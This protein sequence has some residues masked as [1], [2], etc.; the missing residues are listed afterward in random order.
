MPATFSTATDTGR[1]RA[2]NEDALFA[3]PPVF[4]VADGMGGPQ[5]GEIAS[6]ITAKA[7]E[8]YMPQGP[9]AERELPKL[10]EKINLNIYQLAL[11]ENRPGMG[12]TVTAAQVDGRSVVLAHVGDSRAY[13][14]RGG[15]LRQ[16]T[17]DHS[18]V[19]EMVRSGELTAEEASDH[20]QRSIITRA[21]GVD[22]AVEVDTSRLDWEPG[23]V[24]ML[25]S[26]GLYSMIPDGEIAG[27]L[28][29]WDD[30]NGMAGAL[31]AKANE[32]GG[33][34]NISVVLFCPDGSVRGEVAGEAD[35]GVLRLP[36]HA[37]FDFELPQSVLDGAR[38]PA[39]KGFWGH[40]RRSWFF[41]TTPGVLVTGITVFLLLL[42]AGWLGTREIYF[43]GVSD[44]RIAIYQGVPYSVGPL[45]LFSIS[46]QSPVKYDDLASFEQDA[47]NSEELHW[48]GTALKIL[49]NYSAEMRQ[50][51]QQQ[52][53]AQAAAA[54]AGTDTTGAPGSGGPPAS[55]APGA[56]ATG[57][58]AVPSANGGVAP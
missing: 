10:I 13:L 22:E 2:S 15:E 11:T 26:D 40:V 54:A 46:Y 30:L 47:V 25:C 19:A 37:G 41:R 8:W 44:G 4:M 17:A 32:N 42:F 49:D 5:G 53:A 20:P 51:Q 6:G 28:Q 3:R 29:R 45:N 16:L 58:L 39:P 14:W 33:H 23:D 35:T 27:L 38:A 48:H 9:D 1:V 57:S 31:I 7:F 21:L 43:V 36:D 34:D 12:T 55:G 52:Q 24:F 50:K 56:G 18:L